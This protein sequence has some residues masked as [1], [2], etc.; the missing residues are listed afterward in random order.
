VLESSQ[1]FCGPVAD[2]SQSDGLLRQPLVMPT[3]TPVFQLLGTSFVK[4]TNILENE[5]TFMQP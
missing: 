2:R 3:N 4:D 1:L 5:P